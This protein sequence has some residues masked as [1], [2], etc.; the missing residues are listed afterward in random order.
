MRT[1]T[2][3][4]YNGKTI[5]I[6]PSNGF[7]EEGQRNVGFYNVFVNGDNWILENIQGKENAIFQAKGFIDEVT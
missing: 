5:E 4:R 2:T 6:V 3:I 1:T 7:A